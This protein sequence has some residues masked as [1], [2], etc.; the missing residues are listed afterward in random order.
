MVG[1]TSSA[2]RSRSVGNFEVLEEVGQGG[3]GFIR[4]ARQPALG[5]LVVMKR[6]HRRIL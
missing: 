6:F 3:M 5:R 2:R 1:S 4:L